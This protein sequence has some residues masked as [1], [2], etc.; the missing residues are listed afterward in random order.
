MQ[1]ARLEPRTLPPG[2]GLIPLVSGDCKFHL[3]HNGRTCREGGYQSWGPEGCIGVY[4]VNDRRGEED[5][6]Q[7]ST[8]KAKTLRNTS[9][10]FVQETVSSSV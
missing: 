2:P 9:V 3:I 8:E 6:S 5:H 4:H 10:L 7:H 1:K